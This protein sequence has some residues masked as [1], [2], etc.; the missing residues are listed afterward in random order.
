MN[1]LRRFFILP[2]S[3][4][5]SAGLSFLLIV[6]I[7]ELLPTKSNIL[8]VLG[9]ELKTT[10][11]VTR[12]PPAPSKGEAGWNGVAE[13][14]TVTAG[15][16]VHDDE[17]VQNPLLYIEAACKRKC[18][19]ES[20]KH[21]QLLACYQQC[22]TIRSKDDSKE[23]DNQ[24][25]SVHEQEDDPSPYQTQLQTQLAKA[26]EEEQEIRFLFELRA[27]TGHPII[28]AIYLLL[29][30][31][32]WIQLFILLLEFH[33]DKP[34]TMAGF[35][36]PEFRNAITD[37]TRNA[38]PAL[39]I[40]GTIYSLVNISMSGEMR[41]QLGLETDVTNMILSGFYLAA[42]TTLAGLAVHIVN[43][44]LYT[45]FAFEEGQHAQ[46]RNK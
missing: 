25:G 39:G 8:L 16:V 28:I 22:E 9:E 40:M 33:H 27:S 14:G 2:V 35:N 31:S 24:S 37:F 36:F 10:E 29:W 5:L 41:Q 32:L 13:Q 1:L 34:S 3:F 4:L 6:F 11:A 20:S 23:T 21:T 46:E 17:P 26:Y 45:L 15:D 19:E 42:F 44:A 12:T 18:S 38:P 7:F 43:S 30:V